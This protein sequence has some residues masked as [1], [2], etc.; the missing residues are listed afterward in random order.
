MKTLAVGYIIRIHSS[1]VIIILKKVP[2][3]PL[4]ATSKKKKQTNKER[5]INK[6][7]SKQTNKHPRLP[8]YFS[9]NK[10]FQIIYFK[11]WLPS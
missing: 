9:Q 3:K 4:K 10:I 5:K 11:P 8:K 7:I 6:E 2:D 1:L